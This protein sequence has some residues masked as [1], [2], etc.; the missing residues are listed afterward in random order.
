MFLATG[1]VSRVRIAVDRYAHTVRTIRTG[2]LQQQ[3]KI[4]ALEF[5]VFTYST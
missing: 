3:V 5:F 4:G 2:S 1:I